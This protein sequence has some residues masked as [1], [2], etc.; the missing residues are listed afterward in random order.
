MREP[1]GHLE[2]ETEKPEQTEQMAQGN[3]YLSGIFW[4]HI[5]TQWQLLPWPPANTEYIKPKNQANV[6]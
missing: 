3:S 5:L 2:S 1:D 4:N 6:T